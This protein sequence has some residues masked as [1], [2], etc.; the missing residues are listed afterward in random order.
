MKMN[1]S[2]IGCPSAVFS[3]IKMMHVDNLA[4]VEILFSK[5]IITH[6]WCRHSTCTRTS[7]RIFTCLIKYPHSS[8]DT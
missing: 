5:G 8:R 4:C 7:V 2:Y 1:V 3:S 6:V